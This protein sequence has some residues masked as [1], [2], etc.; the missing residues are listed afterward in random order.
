MK[1]FVF[2]ESRNTFVE[3]RSADGIEFSRIRDNICS[4]TVF[5]PEIRQN[6]F[7]LSEVN[8]PL[9]PI[10]ELLVDEIFQ[11]FTIFQFCAILL[12]IFDEYVLYATAIFTATAIAMVA[13]IYETRVNENNIRKFAGTPAQI[14]V[15]RGSSKYTSPCESS[16]VFCPATLA[17][18]LTP[19]KSLFLVPG[20]IIALQHNTLVPA[21]CVLIYGSVTVSEATLTGENI[22]IIKTS[23]DWEDANPRRKFYAEDFSSNML[24]AGSTIISASSSDL[25]QH[26]MRD[27]CNVHQ[28]EAADCLHDSEVPAFAYV[29]STGFCTAY[30]R[31][32][33]AVFFPSA[34]VNFN[35]TT[36]ALRFVGVLS[37]LALIGG[38]I[39]FAI[40]HSRQ[41]PMKSLVFRFLDL[42]TVA[43]PPAL[44]AALNVGTAIALRRMSHKLNI[45]CVEPSRI[46]A[47]GRVSVAVFDKTGTLTENDVKISDVLV[48]ECSK[49]RL[50]S[51]AIEE[52]DLIFTDSE[53]QL[54]PL[55]ANSESSIFLKRCMGL[56]H[57]LSFVGNE[58]RGDH[59]DVEMLFHSGWSFTPGLE[60]QSPE[61]FQLFSSESS[62][63]Y[64]GAKVVKRFQFEGK[65]RKQ[66]TVIELCEQT[67]KKG[68]KT[69]L[70]TFCKGSPET[71]FLLCSKSTHPP[72]CEEA[73]RSYTAQGFRV[74]AL[75]GKVLKGMM[76]SDI[77]S[78]DRSLLEK[79]MQ[80][81]GIV[82][83]KS[84]LKPNTKAT[85]AALT[86]SSCICKMATGD[87]PLTGLAVAKESNLIDSKNYAKDVVI[88][89]NLVTTPPPD[90]E[91]NN[92]ETPHEFPK[93]SDPINESEFLQWEFREFEPETGHLIRKQKASNIKYLEFEHDLRCI[94]MVITGPALRR[95]RDLWL[96]FPHTV[97]DFL[98]FFVSKKNSGDVVGSISMHIFEFV[99]RFGVVFSQMAPEDK[100]QLVSSLRSL[101]ERPL[102]LMCG[103]GAN[104]CSALKASDVSVAVSTEGASL[105][106]SFCIQ[107]DISGCLDVI[108]EGRASLVTAFQ[109]F[110]FIAASS[111]IQF[112]SAMALNGFGA[113]L[114]DIQYL[115]VDLFVVLPLSFLMSSV[116][117]ATT[118]TKEH[119]ICSLT[120]KSVLASVIV[121]ALIAFIVLLSS[122]LTLVYFP[123]YVPL[124]PLRASEDQRSHINTTIFIC[125][126]FLYPVASFAL[127]KNEPW[128][129]PWH[130]S[131]WY[132]MAI[133]G[134]LGFFAL[135][136][137]F[138][139]SS[140][141]RS[142][143][144]VPLPPSFEW[145]LILIVAVGSL[146][147]IFVE[148]YV[149]LCFESR[150]SKRDSVKLNIQTCP[151]RGATSDEKEKSIW[152]LDCQTTRKNRASSIKSWCSRV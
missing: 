62:G 23:I 48:N 66:T 69:S 25:N 13:D 151:K 136:M 116:D 65:L 3:F 142:I 68:Q 90:L 56:C 117:T 52:A 51:T 124:D 107:Q 71:I 88:S 104:D 89:C 105:S 130:S 81:L 114:T 123:G 87:Q 33:Q 86:M 113:N 39:S 115:V 119:P 147:F 85:L 70:I 20:D 95:L 101:P 64:L 9:T 146:S 100:H 4:G 41:I 74:I 137:L 1:K 102:V 145:R 27:R 29:L 42:F 50:K 82:V 37:V 2:V 125:S 24:F 79:E 45:S 47:A 12:W 38:T 149:V 78:V 106:G 133:T 108:R 150:D 127:S 97:D 83:L 152:S 143:D 128:R 35:F 92:E 94:P 10:T 75:A 46:A 91:E 138:P 28:M 141:A 67:T 122:V 43:V 57:G 73:V 59:M 98:H 80:L 11:P 63:Q 140:I 31:T 44:P 16:S 36:D 118:I 99:L 77:L 148:N 19:E 60:F 22:P 49:N 84:Y 34:F 53:P 129:K 6:F 103:D 61:N 139:T 120:S 110:K 7:G 121:S 32:I 96:T 58:V 55:S 111:L 15:C 132:V 126:V 18:R 109:S 5:D 144:L 76:S 17:K 135:A 134:S 93:F 112:I 131:K 72:S 30:G 14:L 21:D 8:I 26:E 40:N 54:I